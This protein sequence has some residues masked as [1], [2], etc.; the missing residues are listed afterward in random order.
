MGMLQA[1]LLGVLQGLT[2]FLPVSSSGHLVAAQHLF[3]V[4]SPGILLE[5]ALH[6][7]TLLAIL[8]VLW[9]PI[10]AIVRDTLTGAL[11]LLRGQRVS[12]IA[13]E[14]PHFTT[15][16]ALALG[17]L[18]AGVAYLLLKGA[19]ERCFDSMAI[20]GA[21]LT[22]TGGV[23]LASRYAPQPVTPRVGPVRGLLIGVAQAFALLPGI[24]RS[25]ST[26]VAGCFAGVERDAAGRFSFL[27]A[28]PAIGGATL[29]KSAEAWRSGAHLPVAPLAAGTLAAAVTGAL[30]LV[31]LLRLVHRGHLQWFAAYCIPAG[32]AMLA[33]AVLN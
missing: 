22:V 10:V 23:L 17:T 31:L 4:E 27:L 2:E 24:S 8:V 13:Q 28:L 32:L 29:W 7:G 5:V 12:A 19:I 14:A 18:P 11:M 33:A 25:G 1:V 9:K 3:G 6:F 26:I 30:C 20:S 16:V 15:A 21:L